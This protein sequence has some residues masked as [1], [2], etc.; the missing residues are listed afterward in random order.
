MIELLIVI[1]IIA[2]L[3]AL[4]LPALSAA[5]FFARLA[6]CK[7]NLRQISIGV[8]NYAGDNDEWYAVGK[9]GTNTL[10]RIRSF[11]V[12]NH[13]SFDALAGYFGYENFGNYKDIH[14]DGCNELWQCPQGLKEVPW[15][16]GVPGNNHSGWKASYGMYFSIGSGCSNMSTGTFD[17]PERVM[18]RLGQK[19]TFDAY[20]NMDWPGIDG[21][22]Y[23][24]LASDVCERSLKAMAT[25]HIWG[26]DRGRS[27]NFSY[28]P[29]YFWSNTG[30]S[31]VNYSFADCSVKDFTTA[32]PLFRNT[33]HFSAPRCTGGDPY[34]LPKEWGEQP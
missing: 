31:T 7:S 27:T 13:S 32:I 1:A 5:K 10:G 4:L 29:L 17:E 16:P 15:T 30:R 20:Q 8:T 14:I 2:I 18:R 26:G 23:D 24:I 34:I 6:Q 33:M 11:D 9:D 19:F 21:L 25:N 3:M 28:I 22:K 12:N